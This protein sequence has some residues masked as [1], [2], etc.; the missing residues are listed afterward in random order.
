MIAIGSDHAGFR[1]KGL[2]IKH[3]E[4][5]ALA[6]R[7]FGAFGEDGADYV[8]IGVA[9][10]RAVAACAAQGDGGGDG[11]VGVS[12]DSV[13]QGGSAQAIG[14]GGNAGASAQAIGAG[15][16]DS[17]RGAAQGGSAQS[18][19]GQ[20]DGRCERG[21]LICGTGIGMSITANKVAGI[22]AALCG[23]AYSAELSR[24]HNDANILVLG[25]RVTGEG[26]AIS[27]VDAWLGA[28]FDGGRHLAR[29]NLIAGLEAASRA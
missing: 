6:C 15:G 26:L 29:V 4:A 5:R 22:R 24:R 7:D 20:G 2:I 1:L 18:G 14:G 3:L 10:A 28:P 16:G 21:I 11:A 8:P 17:S 9:V 25:A 19:A 13:S 27:I 23:D 12:Q